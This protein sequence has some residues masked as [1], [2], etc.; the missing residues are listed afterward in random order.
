M[1]K[2]FAA[3]KNLTLV[4][5]W[6]D[7][8]I[9]IVHSFSFR[10]LI[11]RILTFAFSF[12]TL[13]IANL[14][15]SQFRTLH[16]MRPLWV[17]IFQIISACSSRCI[18]TDLAVNSTG[19]FISEPM[20]ERRLFMSMFSNPTRCSDLWRLHWLLGLLLCNCFNSTTLTR[21]PL[22]NVTHR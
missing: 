7:I 21:K 5:D 19:V 10:Q 2:N 22:M 12:S 20:N 9:H 4:T 14:A 17:V 3:D 13:Y 18:V 8:F 1:W 6:F 16:F 11:R 15:H